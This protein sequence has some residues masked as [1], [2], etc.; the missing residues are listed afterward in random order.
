MTKSRSL[1]IVMVSMNNL[2][3]FRVSI[4]S[5]SNLL[6]SQCR[7]IVVDSSSSTEILEES[8]KL[9]E[10]GN[11][12]RYKW[13]DPQGIYHAMNTGVILCKDDSL[14]W[15]L[16][17]GDVVTD[18]SLILELIELI[19]Q[20]DSKW[21]Y[22]LASYDN[23][24]QFPPRLFPKNTENT[25]EALFNS[26]LQIS[27]Q[28][29]LVVKEALVDL[30]GFDTKFRIAA[31]LDFQF[32]LLKCCTPAILSKHLLVVDTSGVSHE[33]QIRT[34]LESFLIRWGRPEFSVIEKF[35]WLMRFV[36]RRFKSSRYIRFGNAK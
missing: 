26:E 33:Q 25:V 10:L 11:D 6:P 13:E 23:D 22:G 2:K 9:I 12:I 35:S 36:L 30:E 20:S 16:N 5:I 1:E 28:S 34:L 15:F 4:E 18:S 14:V 8:N 7:V 24:V 19:T 27:H 21:G 17:P 31:D 3:D 32:K 29:M